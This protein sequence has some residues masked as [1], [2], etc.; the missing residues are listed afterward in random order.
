VSRCEVLR[1]NCKL[2]IENC[3]LQIAGACKRA[4]QICNL[5]FAFS[6]LQSFLVLG[7]LV[8]VG[9]WTGLA[10]SAASERSLFSSEQAR[11]RTGHGSFPHE[12]KEH[13]KVLCAD[14]HLSAKEKPARTDQPMARD[15]PHIACIRC[16]NFAAEFFKTAMGQPSRFC[17]VCH[18]TRRISRADKALKPGVFPTP[19]VSDFDDAF[20]HKAHRKTL[21]AD[22]R[23]VPVS[24]PPYGSQ[25]KAGENPR[26]TD[27]HEQIKKARTDSKDI[28][29]DSSHATCFVCHGGT[30]TE[31]RRTSAE[32]FPYASDCNVCHEL[33]VSG[34]DVRSRSLFGSIK[35]FRHDDHDLDIRPKKRSDF[36]LPTATD[37][38]CSECHKP[39][40][41][42]EK[43][44]AIRLPEAGNCN[45]CHI[46]K[47]PGLPRRLS[48]EVLNKLKEN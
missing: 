17:G 37:R 33:H 30:T 48:D 4:A 45:T 32:S 8:V 43:L 42:I 19:Q 3:K 44:N 16:H 6:T 39:I 12:Q 20:S 22:F 47:K 29:T 5:Q 46:D 24:N 15:F 23:I 26:C 18:E 25:F 41:Q 28:E 14:C 27:C 38:L 35:S 13:I 7:V 11:D 10:S 1:G 36:P 2:K 21:P 40:D 34:R 31:A 9:I